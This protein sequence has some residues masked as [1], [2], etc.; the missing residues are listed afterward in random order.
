MEKLN[1]PKHNLQ[2]KSIENKNYIFEPIR[3]KWLLCTPEEWVRVNCIN[4]IVHTKGYPPS[5]ISVV[6]PVPIGPLIAIA[7]PIDFG[8]EIHCANIC[9]N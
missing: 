4:F 3:K 6:L 1:F 7:F 8:L 2:I 9:M 5:L